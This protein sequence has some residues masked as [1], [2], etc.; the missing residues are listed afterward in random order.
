MGNAHG[1]LHCLPMKVVPGGIE[2][3][4]VFSV[5]LWL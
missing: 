3:Q 2:I 4:V 5:S 1:F